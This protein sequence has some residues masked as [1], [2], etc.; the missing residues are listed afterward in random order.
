MYY[1]LKSSLC[2]TAFYGL[3]FFGFRRLTFH[4]L[5][6]FYLLL[7]LVF[8]LTIPM[9]SYER[10]E[11]I[12]IEPS[13]VS[14]IIY[15][16]ETVT[17]PTDN[18]AFA[19]TPR[20]IESQKIE[21]DWIQI[22]SIIY[23]SGVTIM[24]LLF[25]RNLIL[26]VRILVSSPPFTS[27]SLSERIR[28]LVPERSRRQRSNASFF[29]YI[30]I[31]PDN[32]NP[33]EQNLIIA[34][35]SFHAKQ[36]H[37]LDLLISGIL[38]AIF[39]FNPIIYFYQKSLKQ[40]HEYEV[41]ALMSAKHDSRDYAHLLLKLSVGSNSLIINQFS[42][43]PLS[44][45]IQFLFKTPTKNMKK[46]L[47]FLVI[48]IIGV[49]VMAFV[50]EKVVTVYKEKT[51]P[52]SILKK[53]QKIYLKSKTPIDTTIKKEIIKTGIFTHKIDFNLNLE[54]IDSLKLNIDNQFLVEGKDYIVKGNDIYLAPK[55]SKSKAIIHIYS[56]ATGN[57]GRYKGSNIFT[58]FTKLEQLPYIKL[59]RVSN[60]PIFEVN[61]DK[62]F[63]PKQLSIFY[64]TIKS[65]DLFRT[66][67]EANKLGENPL[68]IIN[69]I[70][71]PSSILYRLNPDAIAEQY[72][73][74]Q[75]DK[76]TILLY[77]EKAK[78]GCIDISTKKGIDIFLKSE[79][80]RKAI[81]QN[82]QKQIQDSQKRVRRIILKDSDGKEY[83]KINV[84]R[85]GGES[86]QLS[87]NYLPVG[88]KV[89][90]LINDKVVSEEE[91]SKSTQ[92]FSSGG[93]G[94]M[95]EENIRKYGESYRKY[96]AFIYL[97]N[98]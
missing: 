65:E 31:N 12:I 61:K 45:R 88:G 63:F 1:L 25:F 59:S 68:V 91:V 9:L 3:Y 71:Y 38:K 20:A 97:E 43:K 87:I 5:N 19:I 60:Q 10:E 72:I 78:D 98:R 93:V 58:E 13:P 52:K 73:S 46:L 51:L 62:P 11:V 34:H 35:E 89:L 2:M 7:S 8:S 14:E 96:D 54:N 56:K 44:E 77:G 28:V 21:F 41:D 55:Y 67:F 80:N 53:E 50:Q 95:N 36:L 30:F 66:T 40:I 27:T 92:Y 48:P 18:Q 79:E 82:V 6:R 70:E 47:Y 39:W 75:N 4:A 32:L 83:E 64:K 23:L 24:L 84:M 33:Y 94:A 26:I 42:T 17:Q 69:Q 49:G 57:Y 16:E 74:S 86:I 29:N 15:P 22:L 37:T 76:N 90:F 85:L 81:I